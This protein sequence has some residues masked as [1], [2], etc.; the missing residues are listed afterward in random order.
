MC[1]SPW[2]RKETRLSDRTEQ[3]EKSRFLN[4]GL[5]LEIKTNPEKKKKKDPIELSV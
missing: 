3:K 4:L 2:G 1:C 5:K